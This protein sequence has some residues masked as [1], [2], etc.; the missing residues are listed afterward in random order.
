M[1][2]T[3]PTN[4]TNSTNPMNPTNPTNPIHVPILDLT[5]QYKTIKPEI[6][7]AVAN[8]L[9]SGRFILGP[10]VK[11]FEEEI[12]KYAGAKHAIGVASGTDAILLSLK[13]FGIGPGDAVIVPSFTFFATAGVVHNVGATPVFADINP[14]TFNLDPADVRRILESSPTNPTN[15][16]NPINSSVVK[17]IIPVHLYGQMADMDEI[18]AIAKEYNI[19]V[20]EDAAQAI[21]AEYRGGVHSSQLNEANEPHELNGLVSK[22]GT[23][24][25]LGCFS[26]F[27]T[28]N[29]GAYGDGGMIVTDDDALAE[30]VRILRVH[31]SKPKYYHR[32]VGTN[33]RLDAIQAAILRVKLPHLDGWTAA[34]QRVAAGYDE[35]LQ[36]VH[37]IE[38]PYRAPDR[39]HIFHQYTIRVLNG[40]RDA[41]QKYLKEHGI[42]TFVYYPL[43]LH[44][45]ECF[46]DLGYK[47]GD[48]PESERASQ[49]VL[50]LP[51]FPELTEEEQEFVI[52]NIRTFFGITS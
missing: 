33:S 15:S 26:F 17:A 8:V 35:M 7:A 52:H 14:K 40:K 41:L 12:A 16:M 28:K 24:G 1:N 46:Q 6:D 44:L 19:A 23:I 50:S 48:L 18:M 25:D 20:V 10:E 13:A 47:N 3:N 45:Q 32:M 29:L 9:A 22:A 27:P 11:A 5:R 42:G 43:P 31:G 34:R 38:V 21:G 49:E 30:R 2:S 4:P 37:G 39:T 36:D 51:V